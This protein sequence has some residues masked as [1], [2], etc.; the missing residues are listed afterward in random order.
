MLLITCRSIATN[1]RCPVLAASMRGGDANRPMA[2]DKSFPSLRLRAAKSECSPIDQ[3]ELVSVVSSPDCICNPR[4]PACPNFNKI[5]DRFRD[6]HP[7]QPLDLHPSGY[8][9][10]PSVSVA[11]R[12]TSARL[13]CYSWCDD[14]V[15][16]SD[17]GTP[18]F[19]PLGETKSTGGNTAHTEP[20][21]RSCSDS[22]EG[23]PGLPCILLIAR[24]FLDCSV[25]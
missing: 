25:A 9:K 3:Y 20:W 17:A 6:Y 5:P 8:T 4:C 14:S 2:F 7:H 23:G 1:L 13:Q 10:A 12:T 16:W 22:S 19:L 18:W 24:Q 11:V 21:A 15:V